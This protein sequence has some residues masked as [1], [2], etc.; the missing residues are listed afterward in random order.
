MV[1]RRL[2]ELEWGPNMDVPTGLGIG[3][4]QWVRVC[5]RSRLPPALMHMCQESREEAQKVY[6]LRCFDSR[7]AELLPNSPQLHE[8]WIWYNPNADIIFFGE[9]T[10]ISTFIRVFSRRECEVIPAIAI[11][12]SGKGETCCDHDDGIHGVNGGV[13]TLQALHGFDPS[14]TLHD[15]RYGGCPGLKE[16]FVVVK[17]KLW[18]HKQG[19]INSSMTLRPATNEGLTK[20]QARFKERLEGEI[21]RVEA[22]ITLLRVGDNVWKGDKMPTFKFVSIAPV[23]WGVNLREPDGMTVSRK[24]LFKLRYASRKDSFKPSHSGWAF[25]KHTE[26][27]TGC[28]IFV[29]EEEYRGED[30]REIGFWGVRKSI[31]AAKKAIEERL[32][33]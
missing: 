28:E 32:V 23:A 26:D 15:Y 2:I 11:V 12:S 6:Q 30:P 19:E 7:V 1:Q 20:G 9:N 4:H 22:E 5:P 13:N 17:S 14:V 27:V 18:L 8:H 10:C 21:V 29:P 33:G 25:M 31:D 24:D 16:V 3:S